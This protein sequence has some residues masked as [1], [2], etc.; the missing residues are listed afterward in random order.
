MANNF[1]NAV[2]TNIAIDSGTLLPFMPSP[3]SKVSIILECDIANTTA[4]AI[5]ASVT[6]TDTLHQ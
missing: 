4:A 5:D 2:K 1:K 3:A 6:I